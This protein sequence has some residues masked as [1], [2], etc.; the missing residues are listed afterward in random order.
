MGSDSDNGGRVHDHHQ[1]HDDVDVCEAVRL[2]GPW[3]VV[4][5]TVPWLVEETVPWALVG[6]P[7]PLLDLQ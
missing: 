2:D 3:L 6:D 4:H 5:Q 1:G 7:A